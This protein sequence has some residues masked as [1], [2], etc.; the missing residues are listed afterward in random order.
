MDIKLKSL[1]EPLNEADLNDFANRLGFEIPQDYIEFLKIYN[2]AIFIE[3]YYIFYPEGTNE[4]L[5]D[6]FYGLGVDGCDLNDY[7]N[8]YFIED[9][10]DKSLVIGRDGV[11]GLILFV[12][13]NSENFEKGIYY[14]DDSHLLST[15][16][17]EH[18]CYFVANSFTEF[19]DSLRFDS[20]R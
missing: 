3:D 5:M 20:K 19:M 16:N 1:G 10:P 6:I 15:S 2:G 4:V 18:N 7:L 14:W 12:T 13:E 8:D 17:D 11:G 9:M